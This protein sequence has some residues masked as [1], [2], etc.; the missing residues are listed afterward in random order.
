MTQNALRH[1]YEL[2]IRGTPQAVWDVLTNDD[3]TKLYQHF[4]MISKTDLRVNGVIE[5]Y[6]GGKV[7]ISGNLLEIIAPSRLMMSFHARWSPEVAADQP[8][9]VTWEITPA[10]PQACKLTLTH[11]GFD[12]TTATLQQVAGGWPETV[13]RLKTLVE[14][15]EPLHVEANYQ[16][17]N[18][19]DS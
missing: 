15:G 2:Y 5:F 14:T 3:K 13:S 18:V 12:G 8:S 17:A 6:L 7:V 19:D 1:V 10:G 4:N 9:R 16:P 11:D